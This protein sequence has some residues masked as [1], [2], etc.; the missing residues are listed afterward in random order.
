M[1]LYMDIHNVDGASA[2][3]IAKAHHADMECQH[4]HGVDCLKYWWNEKQGKLF[5]LID[6]P[7]AE[8]AEAVHREAHGLTALKIIEVDPALAE[9]Y[10]GDSGI[11]SHGAALLPGTTS[12]RRDPGI[13]TIMF[14]DIVDSTALTSQ[15]GDEDAMHL[16]RLHDRIVREE[17]RENAGREIKHT[18]DGIMA[19]FTSAAGAIRCAT[20]IQRRVAEDG[21]VMLRI[22]LSAG[23]PVSE[24]NDL[25]G[26]A[27]QLAARLCGEARPG[28][29]LASSALAD[30]C[31][32][33]KIGFGEPRA[34]TLKGFAEPMQ[35][36]PVLMA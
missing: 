24:H 28:E 33:K 5:C 1:P 19:C 6:A 26:S 29:V 35:A 30:L 12:I 34:A 14:T 23:E 9:G 4:K 13:R 27:V 36:R 17:L 20:N 32:G 21:T 25:F 18:G 31:V 3:A 15:I 10:L 11:D 22:G 8:A 16:V 2:E 7:S